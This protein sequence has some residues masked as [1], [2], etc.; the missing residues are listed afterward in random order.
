[1][2][3]PIIDG[4]AVAEKVREDVARGVEEL[5]AAARVQQGIGDR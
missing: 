2:T 3:A 4:T 5:L 1:M